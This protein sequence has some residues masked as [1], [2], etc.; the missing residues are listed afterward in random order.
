[1]SIS[2]A[3]G[4]WLGDTLDAAE[5]MAQKME[6]A[7]AAPRLVMAEMHAYALGLADETG[8]FIQKMKDM[9]KE[10]RQRAVGRASGTRGGA[11]PAPPSSNTGVKV[12][13]KGPI[14]PVCVV[15]LT[16]LR[17]GNNYDTSKNHGGLLEISYSGRAFR[18]HRGDS[19]NVWYL[20]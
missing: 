11:D 12:P 1:M 14:R 6:Q 9:G 18:G 19:A 5:F 20:G 15:F 7:R 16:I 17:D 8:D 13:G 4:E 10:D 2:R 3:M